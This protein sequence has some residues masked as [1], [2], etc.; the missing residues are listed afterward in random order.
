[1]QAWF[2]NAPIN[3]DFSLK[4]EYISGLA[5]NRQDHDLIYRN[6]TRARTFPAALFS[7]PRELLTE[8]QSKILSGRA[9]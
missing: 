2:A 6:M 4:L 1:M 5:L 9:L 7:G 8:L 3:R